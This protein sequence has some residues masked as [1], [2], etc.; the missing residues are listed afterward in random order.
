MDEAFSKYDDNA[1]E[2]LS[3]E[4]LE[5]IGKNFSRKFIKGEKTSKPV[6]ADESPEEIIQRAIVQN[7][8]KDLAKKHGKKNVKFNK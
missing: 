8:V 2:A 6:T 3:S 7:Y 5:K 1:D 4:E